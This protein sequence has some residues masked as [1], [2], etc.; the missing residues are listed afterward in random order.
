MTLLRIGIAV[1][2]SATLLADT[3]SYTY[4]AAGRLTQVTYPNGKTITYTYDAAGN[5][6]S[7]Q[8]S[9]PSSSSKKDKTAPKQK[10][11][12]HAR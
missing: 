2:A 7:R 1:L 12:G 10:E 9:S 3:T 6:L 5:L 4:D 11:K 8:V